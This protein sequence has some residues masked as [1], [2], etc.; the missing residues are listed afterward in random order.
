MAPRTIHLLTGLV[1]W[2]CS[3]CGFRIDPSAGTDAGNPPHDG[4]SDDSSDGGDAPDASACVWGPWSV[5]QPIVELNSGTLD[6]RPRLSP[7]ERTMTFYSTRTGGLGDRDVYTATR[8]GIGQPFS[9]PVNVAELNTAFSDRDA[10][11]SADGL[12][13]VFSSTRAGEHDVWMATRSTVSLPFSLPLPVAAL[14]TAV[15]EYFTALSSDGRTIYFSSDRP[16]GS[17]G[18]YDVWFSTRADTSSAFTTVENLTA[19]NSASNEYQSLVSPDGREI[20]F[21]STRGGAVDIWVST[22][23][24]TA[25]PFGAATLVTELNF[26]GEN[27]PGWMSSDGQRLYYSHQ[28]SGVSQLY[29]TT[30]TCQ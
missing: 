6:A 30:R 9:N 14:N 17:A 18:G 13:V 16:T 26:V 19:I 24:N 27:H 1:G 25:S 2:A 28:G 22:R 4:T 3:G 29:L 7:D 5:P 20:Y 10:A 15:R 21:S 12:I 8:A 11:Q 23:V